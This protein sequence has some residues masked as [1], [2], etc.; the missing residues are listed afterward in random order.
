M[1]I[2]VRCDELKAGMR[3]AEPL[4]WRGRVMLAEGTELSE[5][6][7]QALRAKFPDHSLRIGDA[8]LDDMIDFEDDSYEREVARTTQRVITDCLSEVQAKFKADRRLDALSVHSIHSSVHEVM[9]YLKDHPVSA[10]LLE[11]LIGGDSYL[12]DRAGSVFYISMLLGAANQDYVAAERERQSSS[13]DLD[14]QVLRDLVPLG[15]GAMLM[16]LGMMRLQ[17][18]YTS[19]DPLTPDLWSQIKEHPQDGVDLLPEDFSA[20]AKM[21]VRTHHENLDGTGYPDGLAQDELH[22]F[23][24]IVRIADAYEAATSTR[25]YREAKSAVRVLWEMAMG[26]YRRC[27]DQRLMATFTRLIQPFPIGAVIR[28][29]DRRFAVVVK[30]N[31]EN[32]V[33]P[34]VM[35]AFDG[36]RQRLSRPGVEGVFMLGCEPGLRGA[37]FR[38]EDLSFIYQDDCRDA[39]RSTVGVWPS[40]FQAAYP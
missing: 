21:I 35:V 24:R 19:E 31:R 22:V 10:A 7:V 6:E 3:L 2:L 13:R 38:G 25:V 27:Y 20:S 36:K 12:S 37:D 40:L 11:R 39:G 9:T 29:R 16:D 30:Y 4:V 28:L 32:P 5:K 14:P 8:Q 26:P 18:L 15:L 33:A 34:Y 1:P 17:Y 23:T